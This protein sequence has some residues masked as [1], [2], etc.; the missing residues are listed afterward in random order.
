[1]KKLYDLITIVHH[2]SKEEPFVILNKPAGLPSAP[3]KEGDVCALS[4]AVEKFPQ[5]KDVKGKKSC[6]RG[7][8][9]RIDND[10]EGLLLIACTQS[11]YDEIIREQTEGR[12]IKHYAAVCDFIGSSRL[13]D[14][15]SPSGIG[16]E[17]TEDS[18]KKYTNEH[19][20]FIT[21]KSRFRPFGLK[22][23]EVRPVNDFSNVA[24]IKKAGEKEYSTEV[25][26]EW[27][28]SRG[29]EAYCTILEGYRHQVRCHLA[30]LGLPIKGD[31]VYNPDFTEGDS[32]M[33][34]A[35]G[36]E[37]MGYK[38]NISS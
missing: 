14:G 15:F 21:I 4:F 8:V 34:R 13:C 10:T 25:S 29:I 22:N 37:F 16:P 3:L 23:R 18:L 9:H 1:M 12:F 5:I 35:V 36:L 27:S 19:K 20:L 2:P 7:L 30:W 38:F 28:D 17:I 32:F 6:E 31:P 11:F 26:L 33:F 24:A